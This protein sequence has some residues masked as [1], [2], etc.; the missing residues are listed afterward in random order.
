MENIVTVIFKTGSQGYQAFSEVKRDIFNDDYVISGMALVKKERGQIMVQESFD[1]G[2]RTV[3]DTIMGGLIGSM[4]GVLG[5]PIGMLLG[6][7]AGLL[8]GSA[9]DTGDMA[10]DITMAER[11]SS[12]M[13]DGDLALIVL[14]QE[15]DE[16]LLDSKFKAFDTVIIRR[17]AATV[18]DEIK[19]AE[20]VQKELEKQAKKELRAQKSAE[21]KANIEK[22]KEKIKT[23]FD[24]FKQKNRQL[25]GARS[26]SK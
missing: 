13:K 18:Q 14:V 15:T 25:V 4:V 12:S 23:A 19:E 20:R 10:K 1:S 9:V 17:D 6:G 26:R 21:R 24:E 22:Q 11:V 8:A 16:A 7:S 3:D 2:L 5:G